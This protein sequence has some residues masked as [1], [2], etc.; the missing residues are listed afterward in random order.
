MP[1]A[2]WSPW[3]GP[4]ISRI[5]IPPQTKG[6]SNSKPPANFPID[7]RWFQEQ[8]VLA[9]Y[10]G[11]KASLRL[12]VE[13]KNHSS[14]ARGIAQWYGTCLVCMGPWIQT[15]PL[16]KNHSSQ[17]EIQTIISTRDS[18]QTLPVELW[19]TFWNF[20][21]VPPDLNSRLFHLECPLKEVH[22]ASSF[23]TILNC[24]WGF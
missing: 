23:F 1:E 7:E 15:P 19:G 6:T 13:I 20:K 3:P 21:W 18:F 24:L 14:G 2:T 4:A 9:L 22:M 12:M 5:G 8:D 17:L 16:E 11:R 10:K